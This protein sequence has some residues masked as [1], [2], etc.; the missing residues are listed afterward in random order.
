MHCKSITN[1]VDGSNNSRWHTF[2]AAV[3]A[4]VVEYTLKNF[5]IP[6]KMEGKLFFY[7]LVFITFNNDNITSIFLNDKAGLNY[8]LQH[9]S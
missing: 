9:S 3:S 6:Q 4:S 7:Y 8:V 5:Y 2:G 1:W